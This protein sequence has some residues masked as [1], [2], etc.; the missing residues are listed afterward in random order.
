MRRWPSQGG[1]SRR[2]TSKLRSGDAGL[3]RWWRSC[4]WPSFRRQSRL[5]PP[6]SLNASC[7]QGVGCA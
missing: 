6:R 2:P 7:A 4:V 5:G 1:R 3:A